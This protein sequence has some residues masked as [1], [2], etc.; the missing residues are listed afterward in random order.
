MMVAEPVLAAPLLKEARHLHFEIRLWDAGQVVANLL[1][2]YDQL[3]S[4]VASQAH[5]GAHA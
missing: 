4:G 5:L 2:R 1:P 3:P